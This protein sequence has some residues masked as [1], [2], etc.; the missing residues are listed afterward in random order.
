MWRIVCLCGLMLGVLHAD[1]RERGIPVTV[2]AYSWSGARA[3]SGVWPHAGMLAV[4]RDVERRLGLRFG[5]RVYLEG[6]GSYVFACRMPPYWMRRVDI[7]LPTARQ[8]RLFGKRR[9]VLASVP[10]REL[11]YMAWMRT[12]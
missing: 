6:L 2:T 1:A 4:S 8:A 5:Q 12:L 7:Y 3:A 9:S 10:G 11:P